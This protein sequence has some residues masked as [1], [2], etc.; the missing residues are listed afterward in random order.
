MKE[1][2]ILFSAPMIKAILSGAKSQTRRI[3]NPDT[4]RVRLPATVR[5]DVPFESF[6]AVPGRRGTA[7]AT[8]YGAP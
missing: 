7:E 1:R 8:T 2:P 4:L 3:V 5:G 6:Q